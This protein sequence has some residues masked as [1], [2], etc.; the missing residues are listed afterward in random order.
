M[1]RGDAFVHGHFP[2]SAR[3]LDRFSGEYV[4]MTLLRHPVDRW[5]SRFRYDKL[6]YSRRDRLPRR[7]YEGPLEEEIRAVMASERGVELARAYTWYLGG[8]HADGRI[9]SPAAV[10]LVKENLTR[11]DIV[12]T[13]EDWAPIVDGFERHF[14]TRLEIPT[15]NRTS[16]LEKARG[17]DYDVVGTVEAAGLRPEIEALCAQDME[18]YEYCVELAGGGRAEGA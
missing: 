10:A 4:F 7:D 1:F 2:I 15:Y 16:E 17:L 13:S 18:I 9:D 8:I 5:I 12:G 14:G 11:F 6:R 3:L